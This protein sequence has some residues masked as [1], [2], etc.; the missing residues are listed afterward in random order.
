MMIIVDSNILI[1]SESANT[2]E[3]NIALSKFQDALRQD[4]I[5]INVI[6]ASEVFHRLQWLL[7]KTEATIRVSRIITAPRVSYLEFSSSSI[8]KAMALCRDF[9]LRI[10][11]ALIAQQA[12]ESGAS[13]LTDNI[14]DFGKIATVKLIPLR[15]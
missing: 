9:G 1:F 14:K 11:D 8:A 5:G 15:S 12:L 3:H 10:N 13:L 7:G 2:P 6:I 4:D